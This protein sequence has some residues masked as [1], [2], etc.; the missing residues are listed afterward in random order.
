MLT[1]Y[2]MKA[3]SY[4]T[5]LL[6]RAVRRLIGESIGRLAWYIVPKWRRK[7]AVGNIE[8]CLQVK[9]DDALQIAKASV[10]RFGHM[11]MEELYFPRIN[12]ANI[13]E[14]ITFKGL[15]YLEQA[16]AEGKGVVFATAHYG[17]WELTA[18]AV[19]L[20]GYPEVSIGRKQDN[21]GADRFIHE[22]REMHG[23]K[24]LYKTGVLEMARLLKSGHCLGLLMDHD[25][26]HEGLRL[27]FFGRDS[28]VPAGPAALSRMADAPIVP[29]LSYSVG[30]GH[31]IQEF[32]PIVRTPKTKDRASDIETTTV[33]LLE[34]IEG[35]I[36]LRPREWFWLHNRWRLNKD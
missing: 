16:F 36:R 22:Y 2:I 19:A 23:A 35:Q 24:M 32:F 21:C 5:C 31:Y 3:A 13:Q 1:Y 14:L 17:N 18:T 8:S 20:A 30:G 12:K 33:K 27:K 15:E 34:L 25:G 9:P 11:L 28:F 6:P 4:V 29:T 7:M 10:S 26:G